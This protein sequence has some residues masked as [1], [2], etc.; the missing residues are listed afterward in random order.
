M[1]NLIRQENFNNNDLLLTEKLNIS[2]F[3]TLFS[4]IIKELK[5]NF[6]FITTFGTTI[7]VFFPIFQNLVKNSEINLKIT[8][9]DI[10]LLTICAISVLVNENSREINKIKT[11]LNEKGLS[12]LINKFIEFIKNINKIF[13]SITKNSG[14]VIVNIVDMFSYT[15]LYTPFLIA[16]YDLIQSYNINFSTFGDNFST[17]GFTISTSLGLLTITAKHFISLLIKKISRLTKK[18]VIT[19][20]LDIDNIINELI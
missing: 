1:K 11:I 5:L 17:M 13:S 9:T 7:P 14:K 15:A 16:L 3:S 20:N 18:K 2:K 4:K 6:Y 8:D 12:E 19:E 10:V